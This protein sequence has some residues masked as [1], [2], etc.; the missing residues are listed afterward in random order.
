MRS[1]IDALPLDRYATNDGGMDWE[2]AENQVAKMKNKSKKALTVSVKNYD[3][4]AKRKAGEAITDALTELD[5]QKQKKK[6][7]KKKDR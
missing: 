7:S 2:E 3:K 4:A 6:K 1:M 5:P